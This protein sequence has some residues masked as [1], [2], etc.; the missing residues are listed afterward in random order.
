VTVWS[1]R[2]LV[3]AR[4]VRSMRTDMLRM[5]NTERSGLREVASRSTKPSKL[6]SDLLSNGEVYVYVQESYKEQS[7]GGPIK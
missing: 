7:I 6:V 1:S 3:A 4:G 5:Q 2:L